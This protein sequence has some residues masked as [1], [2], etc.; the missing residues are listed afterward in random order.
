MRYSKL[1]NEQLCRAVIES[2]EAILALEKY[3]RHLAVGA[4]LPTDD[5]ARA[6]IME[7]SR[8]LLA[9]INGDV[10]ALDEEL[11]RRG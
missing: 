7:S 9:Q 4:G 8:K 6:Q 2:R 1:S 3:Q 11:A 10:H 5:V